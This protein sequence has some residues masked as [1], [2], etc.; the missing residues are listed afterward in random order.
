MDLSIPMIDEREREY[1]NNLIKSELPELNSKPF[2]T[3]YEEDQLGG[4]IRNLEYWLRDNFA[5]L[6]LYSE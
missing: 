5:E 4:M 3:L 2:I 6:K 1:L